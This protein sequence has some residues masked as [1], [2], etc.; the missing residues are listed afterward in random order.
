MLQ[1]L[2]STHSGAEEHESIHK[3]GGNQENSS[4]NG[5]DSEAKENQN[6]GTV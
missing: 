2:G 4:D 1:G 5:A 3:A 6:R